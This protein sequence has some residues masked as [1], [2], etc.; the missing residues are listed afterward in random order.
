[1]ADAKDPAYTL[2]YGGSFPAATGYR[3]TYG[4]AAPETDESRYEAAVGLIQRGFYSYDNGRNG[5]AIHLFDRAES[6]LVPLIRTQGDH[7]PLMWRGSLASAYINRGGAKRVADGHGPKAAVADYD[8]AISMLEKFRDD[9]LKKDG[10]SWTPG[11]R[12]ALATAYMNRGIAKRSAEGYGSEAAIADYDLAIPVL[13]KL[14]DDLL[15]QDEAAWTPNY[16]D[17]LAG[18]Y[19]NRGVAK[20]SADGHGPQAAIADYDLAIRVREK[21]RDDL[22]EE[23]EAAWAPDYRIRLAEAFMNRGTVK[24]NAGGDGLKAAINDYNLAIG[25]FGLLVDPLRWFPAVASYLECCFNLVVALN[26]TRQAVRALEIGCRGL[27]LARPCEGLDRATL[28]RRKENLFAPTLIACRM[29][30]RW[31]VL[32]ALINAEFDPEA[33]TSACDSETMMLAA[34]DVVEWARDAIRQ[35][36]AATRVLHEVP[37]QAAAD[38]LERL[39][40]RY[41]AGTSASA[42]MR[43]QRAE[44]RGDIAEA[45]AILSAY[46]DRRRLDPEGLMARAAFRGRHLR[47]EAAIDDYVAAAR[48]TVRRPGH[49]EAACHKD[50]LLAVIEAALRQHLIAAAERRD[51]MASESRPS[52]VTLLGPLRDWLLLDKAGTL[53]GRILDG[54]NPSDR[55]AWRGMLEPRLE[56]LWEREAQGAEAETKLR[57]WREGAK[58]G[59]RLLRSLARTLPL[60]WDLYARA[61]ADAWAEI[62]PE[63]RPG[64]DDEMIVEAVVAQVRQATGRLDAHALAPAET[65]VAALLGPVWDGLSR[66]ERRYLACA[67]HALSDQVMRPFA[68][69]PLGCAVETALASRLYGRL[70]QIHRDAERPIP[71]PLG[72]SVFW[73]KLHRHLVDERVP[74]EL[75]GLVGGFTKAAEHLDALPAAP[76]H[77]IDAIG[78]FLRQ[79]PSFATI[80]DDRA[81]RERRKAMLDRL[82]TFRNDAAHPR[83]KPPEGQ[84]I[85]RAWRETV[86]DEEHAFFRWFPGALPLS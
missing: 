70:R 84:D 69:L 40:W 37:L 21:L 26:E 13:E 65:R 7:C 25:L 31:D 41:F 44:A 43:A 2:S 56:Q 4:L 52:L 42:E 64:E 28:R 22:L 83:V 76:A 29:T 63:A 17:A 72:Q 3:I 1:M 49:R 10:V 82:V 55:N 74:V 50:F 23:S 48:V 61:I 19:M 39:R 67:Y 77:M 38:R 71:P 85:E 5:E 18:A 79:Q 35:A 53:L 51:T 86:E 60:Q 57:A 59:E 32:C 8:L 54:L 24:Q 20:R 9:L 34:I 36:D 75:G 62:V 68:P 81:V 80:A 73:S 45:E 16:R 47:Y 58:E 6:I 11:Y 15:A 30:R 27:E 46:L 66:E 33:P 12:H 14:R 78:I